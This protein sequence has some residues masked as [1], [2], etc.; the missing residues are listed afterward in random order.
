MIY[1]SILFLLFQMIVFV[2]IFISIFIFICVY[3]FIHFFSFV[4]IHENASN[5]FFLLIF[6]FF[7]PNLYIIIDQ[8][9]L[10]ILL[11][12]VY[13]PT[14]FSISFPVCTFSYLLPSSSSSSSSHCCD[15]SFLSLLRQKTEVLSFNL[16]RY[17]CF[18]ECNYYISYDH[19]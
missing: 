2:L 14:S 3:I 18:P 11:L 12:F 19:L 9:T 1:L 5:F 13:W 8:L 6:F 7:C 16:Y 15:H 10:F 17:H 4:S